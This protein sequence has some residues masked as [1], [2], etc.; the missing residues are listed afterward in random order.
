MVALNYS[1][2]NRAAGLASGDTFSDMQE[3]Q[4]VAELQEQSIE[5][6]GMAL[7]RQKLADDKAAQDLARE[8]ELAAQAQGFI[9]S[10]DTE[11][12]A[13]WSIANPDYAERVLA[14]QGLIDDADVKRQSDRYVGAVLAAS[15]RAFLEQQVEQFGDQFD[16]S[17]TIEVL[18]SGLND[19]QLRQKS[20]MALAGVDPAKYNS[21]TRAM[22]GSGGGT[23][24]IKEFEYVQGLS[25]PERELYFKTI[26]GEQQTPEQKA[27]AAQ[28]QADLDVQTEQRKA[29]RKTGVKDLSTIAQS[30]KKARQNLGV[31]NK[32][33]SINKS[34][35]SG[36][37]ANQK[38][39]LAKFAG[40]FGIK[41]DGVADSELLRALSNELV[42]NKS[43]QMSGALSNADM[44]FLLDSS[45]TLSQSESGRAKLLEYSEKLE[46][47]Q[48]EY[49][50]AAQKFRKDKGYF[51]QS[52]FEQEFNAESKP[53][54]TDE[55]KTA[56]QPQPEPQPEQKPAQEFT[57]KGGI[58][59]K[60]ID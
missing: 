2:M 14:A 15:P 3:K 12:F 13:K 5:A 55:A 11:A 19:E 18:N 9:N 49:A 57:S 7:A 30:G 46:R 8:D 31:I 16:M 21:I 29:E 42:L 40:E 60:V 25:E 36:L 54:F 38:V 47:R 24:N 33:K 56:T 39:A 44:Q 1:Q 10:G 32:L 43:Q 23:A 45:P 51:S 35:M 59:F 22:G 37:G 52:E 20:L 27:K 41:V 6:G 26:R 28:A 58:K 48:M 17:D 34:A 50:K 4:R 53:L